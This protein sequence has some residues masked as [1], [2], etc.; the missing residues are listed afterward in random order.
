MPNQQR[1]RPQRGFKSHG[2]GRGGRQEPYNR[3][4]RRYSQPD[5]SQPSTSSARPY[6]QQLQAPRRPEPLVDPNDMSTKS[7]DLAECRADLAWI[8]KTRTFIRNKP[9]RI[10]F[11]DIR[12]YPEEDQLRQTLQASVAAAEQTITQDIEAHLQAREQT[13]RQHYQTLMAEKTDEMRQMGFAEP[14]QPAAAAKPAAEAN[15]LNPAIQAQILALIMKAN[16]E[17]K[18][19]KDEDNGDGGPSA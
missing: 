17:C 14:E 2:R 7:F 8:S 19:K 11:P 13:V 12:G 5:D 4:E 10:R 9:Y 16:A 3:Q 18:E 15:L 1:G 6:G